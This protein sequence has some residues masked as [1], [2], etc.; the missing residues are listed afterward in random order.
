[1]IWGRSVKPFVL[2]RRMSAAVILG[3]IA[4]AS[5]ALA[6]GAPYGAD[7]GDDSLEQCQAAAGSPWQSD[8]DTS[9]GAFT[10]NDAY[11]VPPRQA[12]APL[13]VAICG[14]TAICVP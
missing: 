14:A 1:M 6:N 9:D 7:N 8:Q 11:C 13:P 5:P 4:L 10:G 3:L 2:S 12:G